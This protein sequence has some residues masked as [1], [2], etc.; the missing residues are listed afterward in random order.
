MIA[1]G[2]DAD[3]AIEDLAFLEP[4]AFLTRVEDLGLRSDFTDESL[5][6]L[7]ETK[8]QTKYGLS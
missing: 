4:D 5:A 3:Q 8:A 7:T 1:T 2:P 6:R